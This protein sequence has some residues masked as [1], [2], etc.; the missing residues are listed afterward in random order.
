[1]VR[2]YERR[3][4]DDADAVE[5]FTER[6]NRVKQELESMKLE[7]EKARAN[8]MIAPYGFKKMRSKNTAVRKARRGPKA[9]LRKKEKTME[10]QFIQHQLYTLSK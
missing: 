5:F 1:M 6:Y 4:T 10:I 3:K 7:N 2:K 9:P 8:G